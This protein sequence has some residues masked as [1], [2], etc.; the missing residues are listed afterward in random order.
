M[1]TEKIIGY[2]LFIG[3]S[4]A[5]MSSTAE[6]FSITG[7]LP[8]IDFPSLILVLGGTFAVCVIAGTIFSSTSN[9]NIKIN[10][11]HMITNSLILTSL[12]GS[13]IGIL[14]MLTH[15]TDASVIGPSMAIA[16]L[17]P[18][19]GGYCLAL[20]S[21]PKEDQHYKKTGNYTEFS[22]SRIG[23]FGFPILTAFFVLLA[24]CILM[25]S[26]SISDLPT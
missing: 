20:V 5:A 12:M 16:V 1:K 15:L 11:W 25:F 14:K 18:L 8:F 24:F 22:L 2:I 17:S 23:W 13:V 26:I 21:L 4:L 10:R 3:L 9:S 19:V 6:G 7:I